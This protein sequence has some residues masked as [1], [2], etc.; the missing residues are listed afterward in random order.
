MRP[1]GTR[2]HLGPPSTVPAVYSTAVQEAPLQ[3]WGCLGDNQ[4]KGIPTES[5][6]HSAEKLSCLI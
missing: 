5:C 1:V 3:Q 2:P 6:L 4:G